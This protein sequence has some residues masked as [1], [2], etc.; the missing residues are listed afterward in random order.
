MTIL[1]NAENP[2]QLLEN[3]SDFF[4]ALGDNIRRNL[5]IRMVE[6]GKDG[7]SVTSL[8]SSTQLSRP[9]ISHH[10]KILKDC[11]LIKARKSGTHNYYYVDIKE[12]I[13]NIKNFI[14][15]AERLASRT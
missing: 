2:R 8:T 9:A 11:G 3:C 10:L 14:Q 5:F 4:V 15:I 7:I 12:H 6:S 1:D 13:Q